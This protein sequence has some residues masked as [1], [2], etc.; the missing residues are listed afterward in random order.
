VAANFEE[1]WING[2]RSSLAYVASVSVGLS[3]VLNHWL[4]GH[5][6]IG[7]SAKKWPPLPLPL[8]PFFVL[9]PIFGRP[10]SEADAL[11][12][13]KKPTETLATQATFFP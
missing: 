1:K 3:A 5:A 4:F 10:K 6:K 11:N 7:A 12:G 9:A 2:W 8:L 13:R